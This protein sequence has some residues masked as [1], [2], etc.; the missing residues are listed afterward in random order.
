MRILHTLIILTA[1]A[2][3]SHAQSWGDIDYEGEPWV[4]NVS[5]PYKITR[6]LEGRHLAVW[7][8]HG[9]YY[10]IASNSWRWQPDTIWHQ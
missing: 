2:T 9:S 4:K 5:K 6:G 1:I 7:A 8:S 10:D 3:P